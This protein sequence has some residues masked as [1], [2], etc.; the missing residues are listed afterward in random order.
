M[1]KAKA[2]GRPAGST[3]FDKAARKEICKQYRCSEGYNQV[4][5]LL[6]KT[7]RYGSKADVYHNA[8]LQLARSEKTI[9]GLEGKQFNYW[10]DKIV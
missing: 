3:T 5:D 8:L 6:V 10:R 2:P 4:V 1:A 9:T 7:G